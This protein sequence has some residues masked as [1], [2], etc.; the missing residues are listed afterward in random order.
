MIRNHFGARR[1][2]WHPDLRLP[3]PMASLGVHEIAPQESA[4]PNPPVK[5]YHSGWGVG[6]HP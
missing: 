6:L 5:E 3:L 1:R 4:E 2:H